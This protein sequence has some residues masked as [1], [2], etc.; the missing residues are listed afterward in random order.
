MLPPAV[1]FLLLVR[2]QRNLRR[3]GTVEDLERLIRKQTATVIKPEAGKPA[4]VTL[5]GRPLA[6]AHPSRFYHP[7]PTKQRARN[8]K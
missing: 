8:K 6:K 4:Q 2:S 5:N 1:H 7:A 3:E